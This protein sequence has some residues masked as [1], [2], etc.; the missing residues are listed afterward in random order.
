MATIRTLQIQEAQ[1]LAQGTLGEL[2]GIP[3]LA[4][5]RLGRMLP[6][7]SPKGDAAYFEAELMQASGAPS[8]HMLVSA[9]TAT[10]PVLEIAPQGKSYHQRFRE[11]LGH[12]RFR[13][14]WFSP[15]YVVA[16]DE[17]GAKLAEIGI[18]PTPIPPQLQRHVRGESRGQSFVASSHAL[19]R[20]EVFL[21]KPSGPVRPV[22]VPQ[23][24][25]LKA[26]YRPFVARPGQLDRA[27]T[28]TLSIAG[29]AAADT[30]GGAACSYA[31]SWADGREQHPHFLQIPKHSGPNHNDH[32]SGCGPTAWMNLFGWHDK[33]WSPNLLA[34]SPM[35]NDSAIENLTMQCHD[36]IGTYEPWWTFDSDQGFTWPDDMARGLDFAR[37]V[38]HHDCS[39][40]W[41]QD[42]WDTDEDWVFEVARSVMASRRPFIVGY[43]QDWHY[44]I[45]M[46][47][48]QCTTHGWRDHS[49]IWIYPAWSRDES[50]NKWIP[51]E[52][53]FGIY[54][55]YDFRS[56][57]EV[58]SLDEAHETRVQVA[59]PG[60]ANTLRVFS[61]TAVC[62]SLRG[63]GGSWFRDHI[64][65]E[66]GPSYSDGT[67]RGTAGRV[68]LASMSN[69]NTAVNAGWAVD[70][71]RIERN[72]AT[73]RLR[74][75][76]DYAVSD[77][78][79]YL[80]RF[81][82]RVYAL[83]HS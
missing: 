30:S 21:S 46:G 52:T 43:Y 2:R 15:D 22:A 3:A 34:G 71:W 41:R 25:E 58:V 1:S 55:V 50:D 73:G 54:G 63:T 24:A 11:K 38:L 60:D 37:T 76:V 23:Y 61:G 40:F 14:V 17:R 74:V 26:R 75:T 68:A 20:P 66:V 12:E 62:P 35:V 65:F 19:S 80:L 53:I 44:A 28:R 36:S 6:V 83:S 57:R 18:P 10:L 9:T 67:L 29:G 13:V 69:A 32:W 48:A 31:Y 82:Y 64:S 33:Y 39:Y 47:I 42:W 77:S 59:G 27:W 81:D 72:P 16:E 45:G 79:G 7:Y 78:D 8:G 51:K 5:A 70:R 4:A 56:L 49:W